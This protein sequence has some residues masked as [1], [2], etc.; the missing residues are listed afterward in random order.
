MSLRSFWLFALITLAIPTGVQGACR[1][2]DLADKGIKSLFSVS[3]A[4]AG[5]RSV[6]IEFYGHN[7]FQIASSRGTRV[8]TDPFGPIGYPMPDVSGHIVT[9]GREQGNHN[10]VALI[11]GSPKVFRGISGFGSNWTRIQTTVRDV[12]L[13]NI[14]IY[15]RGFAGH[16]KGAAFVFEMDGLCVAHLGD[17][18]DKLNSDQLE[19]IGRVDIALVPVGGRF[20]MDAATALE[21]LKQLKPKIAVPMHY[22]NYSGALETLTSGPFKAEFFSTNTFT[23]SKESLPTATTIYVLKSP[24]RWNYQ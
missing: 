17:L 15:Q 21:V 8:F 14:P 18:S 22:W 7:F 9:V 5:S 6:R 16:L 23:I 11:K 24:D 19:L 3:T 1:N 13:Y 4:H 10:N 12:L 2:I 20:T